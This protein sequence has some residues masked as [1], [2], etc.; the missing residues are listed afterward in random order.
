MPELGL[1]LTGSVRRQLRTHHLGVPGIVL[2]HTLKARDANRRR[3]GE[4]E[5]EDEQ[6]DRMPGYA[7][8]MRVPEGGAEPQSKFM[9]FA[10]RE[11]PRKT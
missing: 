5:V 2:E 11:L 8:E 1:H 6:V 10:A 7:H 3:T 9:S 4:S